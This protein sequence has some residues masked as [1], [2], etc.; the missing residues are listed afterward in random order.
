M[1][2]TLV[3]PGM[4]KGGKICFL[5]LL[6]SVA[7][8]ILVARASLHHTENEQWV[9]AWGAGHVFSVRLFAQEIVRHETYH[10][11]RVSINTLEKQGYT[12]GEILRY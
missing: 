3:D 6:S 12:D 4:P 9:W 1:G 8:H 2:L 5:Y 10:Q 11:A 7:A